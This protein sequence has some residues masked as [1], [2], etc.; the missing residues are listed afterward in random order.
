MYVL[1]D[2]AGCVAG[3]WVLSLMVS[4]CL[5]L[6]RCCECVNRVGQAMSFLIL[7]TMIGPLVL[8]TTRNL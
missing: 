8:A 1:R 3:G 6:G 7:A 4:L 2:C 5:I